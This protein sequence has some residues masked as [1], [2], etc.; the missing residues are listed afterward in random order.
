MNKKVI[1]ERCFTNDIIQTNF[2][3]TFDFGYTIKYGIFTMDEASKTNH[4]ILT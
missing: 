2:Q 1:E 3:T 4:Q